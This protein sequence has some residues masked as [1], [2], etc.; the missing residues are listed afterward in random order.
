MG[1]VEGKIVTARFRSN[2]AEG[3]VHAAIL[4]ENWLVRIAV[5]A[6]NLHFIKRAGFFTI[7]R[8]YMG[9]TFHL[10]FS[11]RSTFL[12]CYLESFMEM[13]PK[14]IWRTFINTMPWR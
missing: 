2:M 5:V 6:R 4:E 3:K 9:L 7:I 12:M 11:E 13:K 1:S 8:P 10:H 14:H